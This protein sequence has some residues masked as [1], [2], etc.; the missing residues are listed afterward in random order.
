MRDLFSNVH[1]I[2]FVRAWQ[3]N[4]NLRSGALPVAEESTAKP[5]TLR[6]A[7]ED[8]VM[9]HFS[10]EQVAEMAIDSWEPSLLRKLLRAQAPRRR[11]GPPDRARK[12]SSS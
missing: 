11:S 9:E 3:S 7:L 1:S 4:K 6:D 2:R 10:E 5:R 8:P 12:R